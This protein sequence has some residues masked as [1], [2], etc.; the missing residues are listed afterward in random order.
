MKTSIVNL[1]YKM[2]DV[3]KALDRRESVS[4]LYH[5]KMKGIIVPVTAGK[6]NGGR[7]NAHPFFGMFAHARKS[8]E[9]EMQDLRG[10][11]Y[12]DI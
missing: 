1:R 10:Y 6:K 5:G 12:H 4:I 9:H 8:V 7:I 3:L 2:K 11:R